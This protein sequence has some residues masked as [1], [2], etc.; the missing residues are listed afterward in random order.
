MVVG[1]DSPGLFVRVVQDTR[2]LRDHLRMHWVRES[3]TLGIRVGSGSILTI[4]FTPSINFVAWVSYSE[5]RCSWL[6]IVRNCS[7]ISSMEVDELLSSE[8]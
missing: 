6:Q 8:T 3:R 1:V 7:S 5:T 4:V 2:F